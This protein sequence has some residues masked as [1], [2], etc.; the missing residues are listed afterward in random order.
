MVEDKKRKIKA[1]L[2][3]LAISIGSP[4]VL[5][6]FLKQSNKPEETEKI[7]TVQTVQPGNS[8]AIVR[9]LANNNKL[10]T[11]RIDQLAEAIGSIPHANR[12]AQEAPNIQTLTLPPPPAPDPPPADLHIDWMESPVT[13]I[14]YLD[15]TK[16][17]Y[18]SSPDEKK[19]HQWWPNILMGLCEDGTIVWK[20]RENQN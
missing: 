1:F 12:I 6:F 4:L 18:E 17:F 13:R 10:L 14:W 20:H 3:I 16:S 9:A 19:S 7:S 2:V 11:D 5:S 8:D 15:Q